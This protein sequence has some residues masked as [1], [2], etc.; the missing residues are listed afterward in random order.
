[1][2]RIEDLLICC[3]KPNQPCAAGL[4]ELKW[5]YYIVLQEQKDPSETSEELTYITSIYCKKPDPI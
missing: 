4:D 2:D 1:M 5:L 3:L